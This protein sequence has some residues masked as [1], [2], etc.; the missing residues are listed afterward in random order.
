MNNIIMNEIILI[1]NINIFYTHKLEKN[2][3]LFFM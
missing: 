2:V 1:Y 3:S